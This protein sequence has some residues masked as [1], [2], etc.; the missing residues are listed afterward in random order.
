MPTDIHSTAGRLTEPDAAIDTGALPDQVA[1]SDCHACSDDVVRSD[2]GAY[3]AAIG[4]TDPRAYVATGRLTEPD[5]AI[6][7]RAVPERVAS[8]DGGA[9]SDADTCADGVWFWSAEPGAI[10]AHSISNAGKGTTKGSAPPTRTTVRRRARALHNGN[11]LAF[12]ARVA[13][14]IPAARSTTRGPR[15]RRLFFFAGLIVLFRLTIRM[16]R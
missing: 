5:A 15:D 9:C 10:T 8:S 16:G 13:G 6:D 12:Q 11:A 7:T 4:P 1:S 14:S 3:F 2:P